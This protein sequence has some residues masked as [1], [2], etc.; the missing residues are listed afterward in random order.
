MLLGRKR[1][2]KNEEH[3]K[4]TQ[5]RMTSPVLPTAPSRDV[6]SPPPSPTGAMN[7]AAFKTVSFY[8]LYCKQVAANI[9]KTPTVTKGNTV[10]PT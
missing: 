8:A 5:V 1:T 9:S 3:M 10:H 7:E 6:S 4:A 2:L